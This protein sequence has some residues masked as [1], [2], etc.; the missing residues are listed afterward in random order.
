MPSP[1]AICIPLRSLSRRPP[2][3]VCQPGPVDKFCGAGPALPRFDGMPEIEVSADAIAEMATSLTEVA[4]ALGDLDLMAEDAGWLPGGPL[5]DAFDEVVTTYARMRI[6]LEQSVED[7]AAA[8]QRAG[9][10]YLQTES[11]TDLSFRP[12][13]AGGFQ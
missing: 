9:V 2:V 10:V 12:R 11:E 13:T 4:Q 1:S 7:L 5:L 3:A 8:A 6:Q